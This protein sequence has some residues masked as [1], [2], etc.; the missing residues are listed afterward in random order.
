[1][2]KILF[3]E[4]DL[5]AAE[6]GRFHRVCSAAHDVQLNGNEYTAAG[7]L[8]QVEDLQEVVDV[9]N[10]GANIILSGVDPAYRIEIDR[11]GFK[12][13]PVKIYAADLDDNTNI[14]TNAVLLH[15]GTA[16]T[17]VTEV[18]YSSNTMTIAISTNSIW[19]ELDK[20]PNLT[21]SSFATHSAIHCYDK[22]GNYAPDE[23]F[24]YVASTSTEE[25]WIS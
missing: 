21:R 17:P 2:H 3:V 16:D 7:Q 1:M 19:G 23:A 8:L 11:N 22:D 20:S 15:A 5:T 6:A 4:L 9:A 12:K 25:Q 13:A 14:A 10:I 18:D 24:K